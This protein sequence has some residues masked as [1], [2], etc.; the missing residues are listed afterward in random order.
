LQTLLAGGERARAASPRG[1]RGADSRRARARRPSPRRAHAIAALSAGD[2]RTA[3]ALHVE[4]TTSDW[5]D[6]GVWLVGLKRM[7]ETLSKPR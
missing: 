6:N 1:A 5:A 3:L 4:L 7:I 2:F